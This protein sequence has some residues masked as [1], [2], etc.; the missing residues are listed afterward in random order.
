MV[1]DVEH[2]L[3][4]HADA[5][6]EV[7][8]VAALVDAAARERPFVLALDV[9]GGVDLD[10]RMLLGEERRLAARDDDDVEVVA[11]RRVGRQ[12]AVE[13]VLITASV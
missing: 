7:D 12:R 4:A 3:A 1:A 9:A 11:P 6:L 2:P 8:D 5:V 13:Q 10:E